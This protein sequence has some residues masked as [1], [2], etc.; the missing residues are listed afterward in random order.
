MPHAPDLALA[1]VRI[2]DLPLDHLSKPWGNLPKVEMTDKALNEQGPSPTEHFRDDP[3]SRDL[4]RRHQHPSQ[5]DVDV[6]VAETGTRP[7]DDDGTLRPHDDV[8]R[9]KV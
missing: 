8:E 4:P 7:V 1:H 5:S 9:M 2:L 6:G 3:T